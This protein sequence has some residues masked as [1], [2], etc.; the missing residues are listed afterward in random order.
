MEQ[1]ITAEELDHLADE[2]VR[3]FLAAY[4]AVSD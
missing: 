1:L 4:G 2:G 3:V